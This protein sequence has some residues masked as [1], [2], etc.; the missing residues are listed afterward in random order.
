M[1]NNDKEQKMKYNKLTRQVINENKKSME[2]AKK[3]AMQR[4][5]NERERAFSESEKWRKKYLNKQLK[6]LARLEA[7]E[8]INI[9]EIRIVTR[10]VRSRTWGANPHTEVTIWG[11]NYC[12]TFTGCASGCGY[13][14]YSS[15]VA[16]ALNKCEHIIKLFCDIKERKIT[17]VRDF[18]PNGDNR[19]IF[20][21]GAGYG[22]I[23]AFEG[24]VGIAST[25]GVLKALGFM[26]VASY[27][28]KM[29]DYV[30]L[31]REGGRRA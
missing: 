22:V 19:R 12:E 21:Y 15:A 8:N 28:G 2:K 27:S 23:P 13:D 11:N 30:T 18:T 20:G 16:D 31:K 4:P 6:K 7:L 17:K 10:W 26:S 25:L 29:E 5:E 14:K 9:T 3:Y 24:G 1:P